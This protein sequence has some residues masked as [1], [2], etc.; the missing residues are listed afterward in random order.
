MLETEQ[1]GVKVYETALRCVMNDE[2]KQEWDKIHARGWRCCKGVM[3][4]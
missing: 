3:P 2:L 4:G 1:G